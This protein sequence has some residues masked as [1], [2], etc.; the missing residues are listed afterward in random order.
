MIQPNDNTKTSLPII[1]SILGPYGLL[2]DN[3]KNFVVYGGIFALF[4][5]VIYMFSG[6]EMMCGSA[7]YRNEH[8]CNANIWIFVL[9]KIVSLAVLCLFMRL[10]NDLLS[11]K[12]VNIVKMWKP[13]IKDL[14]IG[15]LIL[16]FVAT[17]AIAGY[18]LYL[19]Y[20]R[21][22]N[23]DWRIEMMYFT[24]VSL[25]FLPPVLSL[26]FFVYFAFA[27]NGEKLP[28]IS[29]IWQKTAGN[30]FIIIL[31]LLLQLIVVTALSV[32]F[33][34][35]YLITENA[36]KLYIAIAGEFMSNI[37]SLFAVACFMNYCFMQKKFLYERK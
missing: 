35:G 5:S 19:L 4:L 12:P 37:I 32:S 2:L 9:I 13:Q 34:H 17:I 8:Y 33:L 14:K 6:T 26:R 11:N 3:F 25:G 27:A 28:N 18:S 1:A 31:A 10:W 24:V 23:P 30:N 7:L 22:P 36:D 29:E 20:I 15:A 21:V 16:S